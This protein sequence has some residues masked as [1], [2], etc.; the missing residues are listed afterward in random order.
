MKYFDDRAV[1]FLE[2]CTSFR[3][4]TVL[5]AKY[6]VIFVIFLHCHLPKSF[7]IVPG[8]LII[9]SNCKRRGP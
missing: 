7:S 5:S 4:P 9:K 3:V 2:G 1:F 6:L 8:G